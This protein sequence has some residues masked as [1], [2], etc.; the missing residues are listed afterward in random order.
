MNRIGVLKDV[1]YGLK[2]GGG[3]V[4]NLGE[5]GLLAPGS[6]AIFGKGGVL[7]ASDGANV[8]AAFGDVKNATI[9]VGR[10]RGALI[11]EVPRSVKDINRVNSRAFTKPIITVGGTTASL[12]LSFENTGDA[13]VKVYDVTN[14]SKFSIP[15]IAASVYKTANQTPEEVVDAL[16]VKLNAGTAFGG[17]IAAKVVSGA[18]LGI[19]LTP[20]VA[21]V[22][23]A[24]A[25]DGMFANDSIVQTT[26][27]VYGIGAGADIL[28]LEKDFSTEEGNGNY[29]EY[30]AD[31][32]SGVFEALSSAR[33]DAITILYDAF[34]SGPTTRRH[35]SSN[36]LILA[37]VNGAATMTAAALIAI[38]TFVFP[39][40][41]SATSGVE[42]GGDT[43]GDFDG[44]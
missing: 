32:F 12:S 29:T 15:T 25:L 2:T 44:A 27:P 22:Q 20:T 14:T 8:V 1:A 28:Q 18:Y 13:I 16:V 23:I 3:T 34:H 43:G 42:I 7:L 33:Y 6:I 36:R 26:N 10:T 21:G 39:T 35:V 4:A 5:A 19:T 31:F 24:A 37:T 41:T 9:A 38:L 11:L 30:A 17:V 40:A